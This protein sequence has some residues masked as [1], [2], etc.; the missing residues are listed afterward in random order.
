MLA[1]KII[2]N[3]TE[4]HFEFSVWANSCINFLKSILINRENYLWDSCQN[5][6]SSPVSS[7]L[8]GKR[9]NAPVT[10]AFTVWH[11]A[12]KC[13]P[14][15]FAKRL[16][17]KHFSESRDPSYVGSAICPECPEKHWRGKSC[18]LNPQESSQEISQGPSGVISWLS[19]VPS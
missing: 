19:F 1:S 18:W 12:T 15:K 10:S 17:S 4:Y 11:F 16:V 8:R 7:L 14:L 13:T 2:T 5:T 9:E 3:F 6:S